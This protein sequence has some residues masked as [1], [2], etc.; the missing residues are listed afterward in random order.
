VIPQGY[1]LTVRDSAR[2]WWYVIGW[3]G[4][5]GAPCVVPCG[6]AFDGN[7]FPRVLV[8]AESFDADP[9]ALASE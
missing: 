2:R 7:T 6:Q 9:S 5:G 8:D 3:N 4:D 1:P